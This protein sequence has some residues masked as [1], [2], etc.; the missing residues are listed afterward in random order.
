MPVLLPTDVWPHIKALVLLHTTLVLAMWVSNPHFQGL[1]LFYFCTLFLESASTMCL[2]SKKRTTFLIWMKS[3]KVSSFG[4]NNDTLF[5]HSSVCEFWIFFH[6]SYVSKT[7]HKVSNF[8]HSSSFVP[9]CVRG[10]HTHMHTAWLHLLL[11]WIA[12]HDLPLFF[13]LSSQPAY[14]SIEIVLG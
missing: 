8:P 1:L 14:I 10:I 5:T 13:S 9:C 3:W 12:V 7:L 4:G 6:N 11:L 2:V